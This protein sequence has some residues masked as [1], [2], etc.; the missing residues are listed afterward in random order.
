[1]NKTFNLDSQGS[2]L[3]LTKTSFGGI[4]QRD[5]V[6]TMF[7]AL[8]SDN[9]YELYFLIGNGSITTEE[10]QQFS[11]KGYQRPKITARAYTDSDIQDEIQKYD[12]LVIGEFLD[13]Y[14][15]LPIKTFLGYKFLSEKC[16]GKF[17]FVTFTDDDALLDLRQLK[18]LFAETSN[19]ES[20]I[21]CLKGHPIQLNGGKS[22]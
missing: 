17:D 13:T 18:K 4:A 10:V 22:M 21:H 20:S 15:N 12:D 8:L 2:K 3:T 14:D 1:M 9:E 6:R 11:W 19:S 16:S 7:K 5:K